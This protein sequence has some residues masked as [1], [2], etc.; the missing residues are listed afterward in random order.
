MSNDDVTGLASLFLHL[1]SPRTPMHMASVAVFEGAPLRQPDGSLRVH[2]LR[3]QLL[4]RSEHLPRLRQRP[5][6]SLLGLVGQH[7]EDDPHFDITN[8]VRVAAVPEPGDD[9]ELLRL[10]GEL[11]AVPLDMTRPLWELW[12]VDGLAHGRVALVQKLHHALTDG[13]GSV[14][15]ATALLD[16]RR[17][18]LRAPASAATSGPA[19][20]PAPDRPPTAPGGWRRI[21]GLLGAA[22]HPAAP[23]RRMSRLVEAFA[24]FAS[25][26]TVAPR[27]SMNDTVGLHRRLAVCRRSLEPLRAVAHERGVSFNDVLLTG[28]VGGA[29][30]LLASRG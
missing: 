7:W 18:P 11:L 3:R 9:D 6:Q 23:W 17:R 10:C 20:E 28:V 5:S 8:H 16:A 1:E 4:A 12:L 24:T 13:L 26:W 21:G 22:R 25:P 15:L 14:D 29:R 19:S 2:D 27:S 30:V